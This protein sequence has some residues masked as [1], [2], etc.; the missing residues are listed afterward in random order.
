[1]IQ[2]PT[3][4]NIDF[5]PYEYTTNRVDR[6]L[7]PVYRDSYRNFGWIVDDTL[8]ILAPDGSVTFTLKR[9]RR[10]RNRPMLQELQRRCDKALTAISAMERSKTTTATAAA[11]ALG[12]AGSVLLI[13]A[14]LA[15]SLVLS[16]PLLAVGLIAWVLGYFAHGLVRENRSDRLTP[17]IDDQY[18]VVY[19]TGEQA[20]RL[21]A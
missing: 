17:L 19:Q 21:L 7:E 14:L 1:M 3:A 13:G 18:D 2:A 15:G 5:V 8:T 10:L 9:D 4:D 12:V 6:E 16:V 11:L 20:S